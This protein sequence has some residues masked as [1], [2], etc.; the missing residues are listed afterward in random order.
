MWEDP[1]VSEA[2]KI[3]E[4]LARRFQF[5]VRAIFADLRERQTSLGPR[6]V[7]RQRE[8]GPRQAPAPDASDSD[9]STRPGGR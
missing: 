2:R 8:A 5:D 9:A 3:R 4:D 6:L 7:R 1:I